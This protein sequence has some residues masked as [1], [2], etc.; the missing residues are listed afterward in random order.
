MMFAATSG[1]DDASLVS[2]SVGSP[3]L[4]GTTGTV[5]CGQPQR[6]HRPH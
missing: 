4:S 5:F 1:C 6:H 2:F 3:L